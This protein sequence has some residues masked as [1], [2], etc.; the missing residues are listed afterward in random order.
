MKNLVILLFVFSSCVLF[1]QDKNNGYLGKTNFIEATS[2]S[3]IPMM[4]NFLGNYGDSGY[5]STNGSTLTSKSRTWFNTGFRVSLGRA[6]K[7]NFGMSI[8]TGMDFY[9]EVIPDDF[10]YTYTDFSTQDEEIRIRRHENLDIRVLHIMPKFHIANRGSLLPLGL[11]HEIGVGYAMTSIA[12][13]DYVAEFYMYDYTNGNQ[14]IASP[15]PSDYLNYKRRY[16]SLQLL[17][18][19]KM[20]T[21]V[22]KSLF[23]N[24]GFRY[25]IEFGIGDNSPKGN[26]DVPVDKTSSI[27]SD[28]Y[29]RRLLYN[30][31]SFD[32]GVSFV[33]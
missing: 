29:N 30:I 32:L 18:G 22:S 25:T 5:K 27:L 10:F 11:S 21:P 1:G 8:E 26:A 24:Y 3:Y 12:D 7:R 17:Y 4:Y 20:R 16:R 15:D 23:I 2:V 14:N 13:K 28:D 31:A 9:E 19:I 33:F 6:F